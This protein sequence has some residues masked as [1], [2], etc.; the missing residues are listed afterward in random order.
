[1]QTPTNR[2]EVLRVGVGDEIRLERH[3]VLAPVQ[4]VPVD[5]SKELL[6]RDRVP[7]VG[8]AAQPASRQRRVANAK[9]RSPRTEGLDP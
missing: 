1:M 3:L 5:R 4:L 8:A 9:N 6:R 2:V 7:I